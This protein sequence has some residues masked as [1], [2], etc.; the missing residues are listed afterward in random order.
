[1]TTRKFSRREFM[2]L[3]SMVGGSV[4][5]AACGQTGKEGGTSGGTQSEETQTTAVP[6]AEQVEISFMGWG[7]VEEDEAVRAAIDAFQESEP[8]VKVK[9]M[10]TPDSYNEK[11]LA[12]TAAGNPPDTAFVAAGDYKTF[13]NEGLLV[14]ITEMVESDPVIGAKDYFIQPQ[15]E[16]RCSWNDRWYGIGSCW[17]AD[18]VYYNADIFEQEGIEPPS[19]DPA[20]AWD[21]DTFLDVARRLT[22]DKN[23]NHPGEAGFDPENIERFGCDISNYRLHHASFIESNGGHYF[24]PETNLLALDSPEAVEAM[25]AMADLRLSHYV[26]PYTSTFEQ[27]GMDASQ[28]LESGR[29]AMLVDGSWALSWLYKI[30]AKLGTATLPKMKTPATG[31]NAHLHSILK[32]SQQLD[33]SFKWLKFLATE[34]YQLIFLKIGLWLPSQTAL[35]TDEGMAKWYTDRKGPGDGVHPEGYKT[36]IREYIPKNGFPFYEPPGWPEA[37]A[38]LF[39]EIEAIWNGDK[40]TYE[41]M[42]EIV[43]QCNEILLKNMQ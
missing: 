6:Q 11:L 34:Y 29:L 17:V 35:M 18:Q 30:N 21:W 28:M 39:P 14:D 15:E 41:V 36:L 16:K 31:M 37:R 20:K 9:W 27:L 32:G 22:L 33:G 2:K 8:N 13:A 43:P 7:A 4:A 42:Q 12:L 1:M 38:I 19:N 3:A 26:A 24:D 5:L 25:Q 10:H 40:T 23:G